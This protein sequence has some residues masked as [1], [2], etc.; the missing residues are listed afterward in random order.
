MPGSD[1][2]PEA[3]ALGLGDAPGEL[4]DAAHLARQA[5][6]ADHGG[7]IG[8]RPI[9]DRGPHGEGDGQEVDQGS[10][11]TDPD[12]NSQT[13]G[14]ILLN[15]T[16]EAALYGDPLAVQTVQTQFGDNLSE[17]NAAYATV[18]DG[19][20]FLMLT[21]NLEAN[22]NKLE[23]FIDSTAGGNQVFD[24]AGNDNA[25]NMNGL[26]FD[27]GFAPDFHLIVRR[28]GDKFDVDIA[29]LATNEFDFHER[30]L[31]DLGEGS[32]ET[33]T[34]TVNQ[35]PIGV[36][37]DNSNTA[38]VAGGTEAADQLAAAAVTTGI[39]LC[40]DLADLGSPVGDIRIA[41]MVN[42]SDHTFMSNQVLG[43]L[44]APQGN[45]GT[46]SA[47]DF[48]SFDGDQFFTVTVP[49][50]SDLRIT[51]VER[52]SGGSQLQFVVEGLLDGT[53][54]AVLESSALSGFS[55][56]SGVTQPTQVFTASGTTQTV[57]IDID[58]QS[59]ATRFFVVDESP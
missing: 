59:V 6:L 45:L 31:G 53:S 29:N 2:V 52:I 23:I 46:S 12:S 57:V 51:S 50:Q 44:P 17:L 33:P 58:P 18:Q 19:K 7:R 10:D 27:A 25:T 28:G 22:F 9:G 24:S 8:E 34:G 11:P 35:S 43:G 39:E 32:G 47:I 48:T 55:A 4:R 26:T 36:A 21:G 1:D 16:L 30:V 5:D 56:A 41:A 37:Y 13:L 54:Y 40:L 14:I 42:S 3:G 20:L 15:G 49:P 38:G